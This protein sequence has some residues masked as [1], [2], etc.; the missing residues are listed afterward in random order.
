MPDM[1]RPG[2]MNDLYPEAD[3]PPQ[4]TI[5]LGRCV[6]HDDRNQMP[7]VVTWER[8]GSGGDGERALDHLPPGGVP[9]D[10]EHGLLHAVRRAH[11][12]DSVNIP[13]LIERITQPGAETRCSRR[14]QT[15]P[16]ERRHRAASRGLVHPPPNSAAGG[17][18]ER[19]REQAIDFGQRLT[20]T[21]DNSGERHR[22]DEEW[23]YRQQTLKGERTG[24]EVST[25]LRELLERLG[26]EPPPE[27]PGALATHEVWNRQD[28]TSERLI[29]QGAAEL[30]C[31]ISRDAPQLDRT[32]HRAPAP[33][34]V[35]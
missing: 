10:S 34:G 14:R 2:T 24:E 17:G 5:R 22:D 12:H 31:I 11:G 26:D 15:E 8:D 33:H 25:R 30:T 32:P 18:T 7:I 13:E 16:D 3:P 35:R 23:C 27:R 29:F 28:R 19:V 21:Q 1:Y 6:H 20:S 4:R 9:R